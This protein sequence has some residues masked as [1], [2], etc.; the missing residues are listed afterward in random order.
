ME[1]IEINERLA[2][3]HSEKVSE[4][5]DKTHASTLSRVRTVIKHCGYF[6]RKCLN[7]WQ[8]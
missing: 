5:V 4:G 7:D 2:N 1:L 8:V 6:K 3:K